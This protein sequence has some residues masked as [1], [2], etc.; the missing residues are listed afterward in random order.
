M[1]TDQ[2]VQFWINLKEFIV[3]LSVYLSTGAII[4]GNHSSWPL[5]SIKH[6]DLTKVRT[7][8]QLPYLS[9][10]KPIPK[11]VPDQN[12][13]F[14][15]CNEIEVIVFRG[16]WIVL[17]AENKFRSVQNCLHPFDYIIDYILII[18]KG[19]IE[20]S[21]IKQVFRNWIILNGRLEDLYGTK[22]T[23]RLRYPPLHKLIQLILQRRSWVGGNKILIHFSSE[24]R[25]QAQSLHC[26]VH[27]V[28]LP[29]KVLWL[30]IQLW[31]IQS[32][33]TNDQ[34]I[35]NWADNQN[36]NC[37]YNFILRSR[38]HFSYAE[39]IETNIHADQV[40]SS[41]V[42]NLVVVKTINLRCTKPDKVHVWDPV[43]ILVDEVEPNA[44]HEVDVN[45]HINY[46][47]YNFKCSLGLLTRVGI[48]DY[49]VESLDS[50]NLQQAQ[51]T[52]IWR[53]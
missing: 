12:F 31:D 2:L 40:A 24:V 7:C 28:H 16:D 53:N 48:H 50:L 8:I 33:I 5:A 32:H 37:N 14:S 9:L 25:R 11:F 4:D 34:T 49:T 30:S 38:A 13:A 47:L 26:S 52:Q 46:Q 27:C 10:F 44:G 36:W 15:F 6:P 45:E 3:V 23:V 20:V 21:W 41:T 22:N 29:L 43:F 51:Y 17:L 35:D 18:A 1:F 42:F 39:E 19:H